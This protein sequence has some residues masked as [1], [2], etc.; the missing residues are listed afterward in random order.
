MTD[1]VNGIHSLTDLKDF[2]H[3]TLCEE[4]NLLP[5]QFTMSETQLMRQ[6][7]V[8]G[9]RFAIR[10]PRAVRLGAIWASDHNHI[11]FYD[12]RGVRFRKARLRNRLLP[13]PE[14]HAA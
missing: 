5:D 1:C 7:R 2:I 6:G 13:Q 9:M 10:G 14:G 12:A 8:C 4:E 3:K 11:Y